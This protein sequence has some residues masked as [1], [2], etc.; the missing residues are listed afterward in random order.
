MSHERQFYINGQWVDPHGS[1][2]LDV[3]NPAT[4]EAI[5]TIAMGDEEDVNR[6][7]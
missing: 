1:A 4:E 5:A 6:A 2:T 3:I 7:V